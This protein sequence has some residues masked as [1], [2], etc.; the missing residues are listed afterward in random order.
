MTSS[1]EIVLKEVKNPI[2][3]KTPKNIIDAER[4]RKN[5]F[6]ESTDAVD[7]YKMALPTIPA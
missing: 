4:S 2:S 6:R 7:D 3:S 1:A 5:P